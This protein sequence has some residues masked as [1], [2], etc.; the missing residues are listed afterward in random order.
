MSRPVTPVHRKD[1]GGSL[2][3]HRQWDDL[4]LRE[5]SDIMAVAVRHGITPLQDIRDKWNEFAEGGWMP[6]TVGE[7]ADAIY[8]NAVEEPYGDPSLHYNNVDTALIQRLVPDA[9]GHYDDMVKLPNHPSSPSRGTFNGKYFDLTDEGMANPNYTLFGLIDN[10]DAD[11]TLRY[12]NSYVL[13][14]VTVTPEGNYYDDTY[15]NIRIKPWD[16]RI[17][18]KGGGYMPSKAVKDRIAAWVG[19]S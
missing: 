6:D 8:Q 10:G 16:N 15:N 13:P 9:R 19:L 12:N 14:E 3:G 1:E 17:L 4:S 5:Q 18:F 2:D 11:T 7:Y